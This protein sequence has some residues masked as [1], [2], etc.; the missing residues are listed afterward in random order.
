[1][2]Y[3]SELQERLQI[4]GNPETQDWWE[5]YL[6]HEAKFRGLRMIDI[7]SILHKWYFEFR[8]ESVLSVDEQKELALNLIR[9]EYSEDKIAG[10]VFL[11]EILIPDGVIKWQSDL[12]RFADLFTEGWI[13]DWNI[14]DWFC[15]KVLGPLVEQQS[16]GLRPS[17]IGMAEFEQFVA[18]EGIGRS[19]CQFSWKRRRQLSWLH[20]YADRNMCTNSDA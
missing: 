17:D 9:Q 19:I 16:E 10:M 2:D 8:L 14:C 13:S 5:S 1:M 11:Q 15:V 18:A 7:Q 3:I 6:K 12:P 4:K 20:G